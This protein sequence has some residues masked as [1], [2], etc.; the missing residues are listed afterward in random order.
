MAEIQL[1]S[2]TVI[3]ALHKWGNTTFTINDKKLVI[4]HGENKFFDAGPANGKKWEINIDLSIKE[5]NDN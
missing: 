4:K 5:T 3:G 2:N 1:N